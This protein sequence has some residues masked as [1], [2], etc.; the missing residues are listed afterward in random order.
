MI[1][2]QQGQR[3]RLVAFAVW[4]FVIL[5]LA[6]PVVVGMRDTEHVFH[7]GVLAASRDSFQ[8]TTPLKFSAAPGLTLTSGKISFAPEQSS[9]SGEKAAALLSK[10]EGRLVLDDATLSFDASE[11]GK[12]AARQDAE[13]LN[14]DAIAPLVAAL[15][16]LSFD[17][18]TL[19][20][21][22]IVIRKGN[23]AADFL[24]NVKADITCKRKQSLRAKGT[25]DLNG[26]QLS[27]ETTLGTN[28]DR[29]A[30]NQYPLRAVVKGALVQVV[31]D[32]R[33]SLADGFRLQAPHAE[34]TS[35]QLRQMVRWLGAT[36]PGSAGFAE[37]RAKGELEWTERAIAFQK[38]TFE[39][40]N[41]VATGTL[42]LVTGGS[43]PSLEGTLAL[44]GL[45][46]SRYAAAPKPITR[47]LQAPVTTD[48]EANAALGVVLPLIKQFD[49]DLRLSADRV[50]VGGN[51]LGR[52]ATT[53]TLRGG[54]LLADIAEL[55]LDGT[56]H[57]SGQVSVDLNGGEP[58]VAVRGKLEA[59]E[60]ATP[61]NALF[62]YPA[63]H[64]RAD[65]T[66]DLSGAGESLEQLAGTL[67]GKIALALPE[68]GQVGV[69]AGALVAAAKA[70]DLSG[71]GGY[72]RGYTAL[73]QLDARLF[74]TAGIVKL[75]GVKGYEGNTGY[76]AT[77]TVDLLD[78]S[79]DL[80]LSVARGL[81]EDRTPAD[82]A[83]GPDVLQTKGPWRAPLI[84]YMPPV[85]KAALPRVPD[86]T[87]LPEPLV[88]AVPPQN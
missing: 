14:S 58:R 53:L 36:W 31:L 2:G 54:K 48:A 15:S 77:G 68:G 28:L 74:L 60:L 7:G 72:G 4:S 87:V 22:T 24:T 86:A 88:P 83:R 6:L 26:Q 56:A 50:I 63:L 5:V 52:S 17:T 47:S 20:R 34:I 30:G 16:Q 43:R 79:L 66:L 11:D 10:G 49:A 33:L 42:S 62:G 18:L 19:N 21:V 51:T 23:R 3:S 69:D 38:A 70:R 37:F 12:N 39:M 76:S 55:E 27:F 67:A 41:N 71:W 78:R 29:K 80:R 81:S 84:R 61:I 57:G 25:F 73:E 85:E 45:D 35:P 32:G 82:G 9:V 64:G 13:E 1:S 65:V 75:D 46:L 59:L 40:D 8:L 44:K